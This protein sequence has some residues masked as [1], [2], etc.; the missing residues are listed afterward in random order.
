MGEA[1]RAAKCVILAS[2]VRAGVRA[3]LG[4]LPPDL[5]ASQAVSNVR[6]RLVARVE[7]R[8]REPRDLA[9][10]EHELRELTDLAGRL[11]NT[12]WPDVEADDRPGA[13][14]ERLRTS[15]I[16]ARCFVD[17]RP[18]SIPPPMPPMPPMPKGN[19]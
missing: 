16:L 10:M 14:A 15:V 9:T 5:L 8:A 13:A 7:H 2:S 17:R 12:C 4:V 18:T 1:E 19:G 6:A 3:L 11:V